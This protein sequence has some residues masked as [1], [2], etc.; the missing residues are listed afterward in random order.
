MFIGLAMSEMYLGRFG[1]GLMVGWVVWCIVVPLTIEILNQ[2]V[3][4]NSYSERIYIPTFR[5]FSKLLFMLLFS[6]RIG[7]NTYHVNAIDTTQTASANST[8]LFNKKTLKK[9]V[10]I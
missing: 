5:K 3:D 6:P 1:W 2:L 7:H 10:S 8:R 4:I 9:M